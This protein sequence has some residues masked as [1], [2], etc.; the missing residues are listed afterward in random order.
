MQLLAPIRFR[1]VDPDD[2]AAYGDRWWTWD[3]AEVTRLR[4]RELIALEAAVGMTLV[5]I[6]RGMHSDDQDTAATMAAMWIAVHRAG[7]SVTWEQFDP[8]V[9]IADWE[10]VAAAPLDPGEAPAPDSASSTV[11]TPS[12]ESPT[13]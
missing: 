6:L 8:I 13:S 1:F 12:T 10:P 7:H 2:V 4:G 5:A 3:E 9:H 11:E